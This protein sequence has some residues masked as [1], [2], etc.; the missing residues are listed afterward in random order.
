MAKGIAWAAIAGKVLRIRLL[1]ILD[2]GTYEI[3]SYDRALDAHGLT[4]LFRS[5]RD[6]TTVKMVSALLGKQASQ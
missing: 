2:D 6:G 5:D 1:T 4:L 3:Q